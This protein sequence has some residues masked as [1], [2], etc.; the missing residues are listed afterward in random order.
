[1]WP[2]KKKI[3]VEVK[4]VKAESTDIIPS[5]D[6]LLAQSP[7]SDI[8]A[9]TFRNV[10]EEYLQ[11]RRELLNSLDFKKYTRNLTAAA[12]KEWMHNDRDSYEF[13]LVDYKHSECPYELWDVFVPAINDAF[14]ALGLKM[15]RS[16]SPNKY[17]MFYKESFKQVFENIISIDNE[18]PADVKALLSQGPYR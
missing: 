15:G 5:P 13:F 18:V 14:E 11:K 12:I 10:R 7:L 8:I 2:F 17:A 9:D 16:S 6:A 4:E 1:M 3:K